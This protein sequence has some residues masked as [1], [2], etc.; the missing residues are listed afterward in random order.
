[1]EKGYRYKKNIQ[2][3]RCTRIRCS[4]CDTKKKHPKWSK[5]KFCL[6][7]FLLYV[8]L[9]SFNIFIQWQPIGDE[10]FHKEELGR[11]PLYPFL[12]GA[13]LIHLLTFHLFKEYYLHNGPLETNDGGVPGEKRAATKKY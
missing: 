12:F 6:Q 4:R 10:I 7:F 1:M 2:P 5:Y 11:V 13:A 9:A 3:S 8:S